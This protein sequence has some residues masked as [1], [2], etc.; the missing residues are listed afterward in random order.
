MRLAVTLCIAAL[1]LVPCLAQADVPQFMT[2]QGVLRDAAGNPVSDGFYD[3]DFYLYDVA[4]GGTHLWTE[5]HSVYA[6]GGIIEAKLGSVVPFEPLPFDV[7]YWIGIAVEGEAELVPRTELATVPYAGYA[8]TARECEEGDEDWSINGIDVYHETGNVGIGTTT[9]GAR[10]DIQTTGYSTCASLENSGVAQY[11]TLQVRNNSGTAGAF[12]GGYGTT[13]W[14]ETPSAVYGKAGSGYR[15]GSFDSYD[16]PAV[17]ASSDL[18]YALYARTDA[19]DC[20]YF[21]GGPVI[22]NDLLT[23][24]G[25]KMTTG[26]ETGRVL[27]TDA[28]GVGTWQPLPADDDDDWTIAGNDMY[29]AVSGEVGIGTTTPSGKLEVSGSAT[30]AAVYVTHDGASVSRVI[31]V[32]RTSTH[33]SGNDLVELSI[34]GG[35]SDSSQFI[36]CDR[37]GTNVFAVDGSGYIDSAAG[38]EFGGSISAEDYADVVGL[39]TSSA[40]SNHAKIVSGISTATG[41]AS[42]VGVYGESV[43]NDGYGIGCKGV[44]GETGVRGEVLPDAAGQESYYGVYGYV[45]GG[46]GA[47]FGVRGYAYGGYNNYGIYGSATGGVYNYAGFFSG[48]VHVTGTLTAGT[49]SFKI[50]HPLDPENKYL[51]HSSVESDERMNIYNG[52]VV[53]DAMGEAWVQMPDWFEALNQDFRYQLT[54]MGAPGPNLYIAEEIADGRF[55]IAGGEPGAKVSW[56]VSGVR[57]DPVALANRMSVEVEKGAGEAGK[58]LNPE[59]FGKP[60]TM[61]VDYSEEKHDVSTPGEV[62]D[63]VQR[64]E[65]SSD[66]GE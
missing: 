52:N 59:A 4:T 49:K 24:G 35:S 64:H 15:G 45:S 25:F 5:P 13:S 37:G 21:T 55:M 16:E 17:Y 27:T 44:G 61:A 14:Y 8:A 30:A 42:V 46:D 39:F 51:V 62:L 9:P 1:L 18:D 41:N 60:S 22:V 54:P 6:T 3:V 38:A 53:L 23:T 11:F 12:Y 40:P 57:H 66:D 20:A 36:E 2:Y 33:N 28:A 48:S 34:P 63:R 10:L 58:Y 19:G 32:E 29:S 47:N 7:P 50:D 31:D 26:S 56:Q 43:P 65:R